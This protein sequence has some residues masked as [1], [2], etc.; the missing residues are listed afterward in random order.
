[1]ASAEAFGDSRARV[2]DTP[3]GLE[4]T[5]PTRVATFPKTFLPIWLVGWTFGGIMAASILF[6]GNG[7]DGTLFL[8]FWLCAW[9]AAWCLVAFATM[10]MY[11]GREVITISSPTMTVVWQVWRL[12]RQRAYE[13][14]EMSR[15]RFAPP[16][17][18]YGNMQQGMSA[19]GFFGGS[20]AFQYQGR[21]ERFGRGLEEDESN[22]LIANIRQRYTIPD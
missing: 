11:S 4:V 18:D 12:H 2:E 14:S 1:M 8:S 10:N 13:L 6:S 19:L 21:T 20:V 17:S 3:R 5:I 9:L 15:L 7:G 22:Q 16:V